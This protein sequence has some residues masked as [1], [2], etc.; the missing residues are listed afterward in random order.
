MRYRSSIE[1]L[2][3][4][5]FL[6]VIAL[7]IVTGIYSYRQFTSMVTT[8][9]EA[10]RPDMRLITAKALR[11]SLLD[12]ENNVKSFGITQDTVYQDLFYTSVHKAYDR[13]NRLDSMQAGEAIDLS[14]LDSLVTWKLTTLNDLLRSQGAYR[15]RV[16]LDKVLTR[17]EH[18]VEEEIS[19]N[20]SKQNERTRPNGSSRNRLFKKSQSN[21]PTNTSDL[22]NARIP[23]SELNKEV[24]RVK[25]E[26]FNIEESHRLKEL[27]LIHSDRALTERIMALL[28][29]LEVYER[30]QLALSAAEAEQ[31][32]DQT[33]RQIALFCL[34]MGVL[35][36]LMA[37]VMLNY[38]RQSAR[39][40]RALIRAKY[41][42]E[43]LAA[44]KQRFLATMSHELR[45]PL[46]AVAGFIEQLSMSELEDE[47]RK[48]VDIV[49]RSSSH[50]L[51]IINDLLDFSKLQSGKLNLEEVPFSPRDVM[52]EA[53]ELLTPMAASHN[54]PVKCTFQEGTPEVLIGDPYRLR[55]IL[56]N[57]L[58][59][60]IK[61]TESGAIT[62]TMS[63]M[64]LDDEKVAL[65]LEVKD[66]GI[67][68]SEEQAKRVFEEFEQAQN[69]TSRHYGGTG[70]G[71]SIVRMLVQRHHGTIQLQSSPGKG[72]SVQLVLHYK[73]GSKTDLIAQTDDQQKEV[74]LRS[75]LNILVAD[76]EEY[77]RQLINTVLQKQ[78]AIVLEAASGRE[79]MEHIQKRRFD[80]VLMDMRMPEMNG[81]E[82]T[83]EIRRLT[84]ENQQVII[85]ALT[86]SADDESHQRFYDAGVNGIVP[87]PFSEMELLGEME[88]L[89]SK[90]RQTVAQTM[91]GNVGHMQDLPPLNLTELKR[92][93][94]KDGKFY[95]KMLNLF[96][97]GVHDGF[98]EVQLALGKGDWDSLGDHAHKM[99]SPC[100]HVG[101]TRLVDHLKDIESMCKE[102]KV[103]DEM[104]DII[105]RAKEEADRVLDEV[106]KELKQLRQE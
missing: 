105:T 96:V 106:E 55:Q 49:K 81:I 25:K 42:A 85:I 11:N 87:K 53:C 100:R 12:A 70:L 46:N 8:T 97:K 33:N 28:D 21:V 71:L 99:C 66:T 82:A 88:R 92:L 69:S 84:G 62:V 56:L 22:Q 4:F 80:V 1:Y 91:S 73:V 75:G 103:T 13:L 95:E 19:E 72:T 79:V 40:R 35:L 60:A 9:S 16:A 37:L 52:E 26:E 86:G 63:S 29:Q 90:D 77:N 45:T 50:L 76:D 32:L 34:A 47:Q 23:L 38:I 64:Q 31:T 5:A 59:N 102:H 48:Q 20:P 7:V 43:D 51:H 15:V 17:I 41:E 2:I 36:V 6:V 74:R 101:A 89:L 54:L 93:S 18:S 14:L 10:A 57:L 61:F 3:A 58:S 98:E 39:Y 44:T 78:Q 27:N 67:G 65:G 24:L 68:M 83:G 104:S 30:K 94:D